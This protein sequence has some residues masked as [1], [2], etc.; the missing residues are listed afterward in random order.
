MT[1]FDR[2]R[3][4]NYLPSKL[5]KLRKH[6][7]YSQQF[8]ADKLNIDVI[9]YMGYENG[10]SMINYSQMKKLA[11]LYH[12]SMNEMFENSDEVTLYKTNSD[13]DQI[14]AKYFN[15]KNSVKNKIKGFIINHKIATSIIGILIVAIIVLSIVLNNVTKPYTINRENKNRL[16]V[17]DTTVV[18]I[19]DSGAI[20][21]KGSNDNGQLNDL[22]MTGAIKVCEGDGF[23]I[24]LKEDGTI[25][26]AGVISEYENEISN[27]KNIVDIAAGSNHIVGV[28]SNGKVYCVGNSDVCDIEETKNVVKV[29]ASAN[30]AIAIKEN[31]E[32][33]V[34]GNVAGSSF[35]KDSTSILDIASS[36]NILVIL[37][38]DGSL[39]VY[40]KTGTY[41]KAETW[42][43]IVDV[44]CGNDFVAALDSNGRVYIDINNDEYKQK[45][46]EWSN[47]I[48]IDAGKDYLIAFDGKN[49]YGIGEN[50]Y[51]QFEKEEK[52]KVTLEKVK[53]IKYSTDDEF[54]YIQFDGVNNASD[55]Q[56]SIDVGT[57]LSNY[58]DGLERTYFKVENMVEGKTYVI[59]VVACGE[60]NY[61]NSD[62]ANES[63]VYQKPKKLIDVNVSQFIGKNRQEL[64][65]YLFS[66][67]V[68][69]K[70]DIDETVPCS[71]EEE[72]VVN[73]DGLQD[74]K[75]SEDDLTTQIVRYTYC[76]KVVEEQ[77]VEEQ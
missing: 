39:K 4:M 61:K 11:N 35:L 68:T 5:T 49:I 25:K 37:N 14:N 23:T 66:L 64:E 57:G 45:V 3:L 69:F 17:S 41:L 1:F 58:T 29:F 60:G 36:E 13:T 22:A 56:V 2:I 71:G 32:V 30:A 31:G 48:A 51:N 18:Y 42:D 52:Q 59:S 46:N 9:K 77:D 7:N 6:Y 16:S 62:V 74:R 38:N 53:N 72:V 70:G 63:F 8:V 20:G 65:D 54:I 44:A 50:S 15:S 47:I 10:N 43:D 40:Q 34:K 12:I 21:F 75:Y 26:C 27:W 33:V 28:D 73:I 67:D 24:V 55:Y 76:S 19:D